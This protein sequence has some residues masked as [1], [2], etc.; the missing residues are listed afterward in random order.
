MGSKIKEA[1]DVIA[2]DRIIFRID[3]PFHHP[4]IEIQKF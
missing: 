1:Y 4:I 2:K 3:A